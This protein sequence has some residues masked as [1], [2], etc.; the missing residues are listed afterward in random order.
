M[1]IEE[2]SNVDVTISSPLPAAEI[3]SVSET[4]VEEVI[5]QSKFRESLIGFSSEISVVANSD[6]SDKEAFALCRKLFRELRMERQRYFPIKNLKSKKQK[7]GK[8]KKK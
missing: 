8:G 6:M 1:S 2:T 7:K 3:E 4:I 5:K